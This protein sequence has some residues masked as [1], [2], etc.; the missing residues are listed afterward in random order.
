MGEDQDLMQKLQELMVSLQLKERDMQNQHAQIE[1]L[2]ANNELRD[3]EFRELQNQVN[4]KS[5]E[6]T[7]LRSFFDKAEA[8]K[9][10]L[11]HQVNDLT[12]QLARVTNEL[13]AC[14][15]ELATKAEA[16]EANPEELEELQ[17]EIEGLKETIAKE[18]KDHLLQVSNRFKR[19]LEIL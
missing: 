4:E 1:E 6:L 16:A 18:R 15:E 2:R 8:E 13:Q 7:T 14:Q 12:Q 5:A 9:D 10:L 11:S 3:M 17:E 19:C